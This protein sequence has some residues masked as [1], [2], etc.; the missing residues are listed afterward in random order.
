MSQKELSCTPTLKSC[1]W[2]AS[3]R[4]PQVILELALIYN[5]YTILIV[6]IGRRLF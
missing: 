3:P 1:L 4:W 5:I 2:E 6:G